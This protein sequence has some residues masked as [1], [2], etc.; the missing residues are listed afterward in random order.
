MTS[1]APAR[2][3]ISAPFVLLLASLTAIGP[4]TIDLYL[5]AFPE[6]VTELGT[7]D[8]RVQLTMTAT[9]AGL[10]VGQLLLG[11]LS[12]AYGR[13]RPLL[14]ALGVYVA[15]SV[16]IIGVGSIEMLTVLRALQGLSGGA[17]MVLAM[18]VVRDSYSGIGMSR[19]ISRLMLV[20]GVAPILAPSIGAQIL[21]VGSWR[22]MFGVLAAFGVLLF[23]L[24]ALFLK[25]TLPREARR[26]GGTRTAVASYRSLLTDWSYIGVVLMGAFYMGAMFAYVA[27][28]TFVFQQGFELSA[29]EFG[30]IFGA[31]ALAV[32]IGS[33]VNGA[34]VSRFTPERIVTTAI[35]AGWVLSLAL[36]VVASTVAANGSGLVPLVALL[37]PT[38]GTV[39]FVMPSVPA[40]VLEHNGHRA[41]S[42]AALNGAMGFVMGA[43]ISPVSSLLGGGPTAMAGV[44]FAVITISGVLLLAVQRR[45]ASAS[46]AAVA[47]PVVADLD[48]QVEPAQP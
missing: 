37:I 33:Q 11:S 32:T 8:A 3:R 6:I 14:I 12:D 34:L 29:S 27:S 17:G 13:R 10:A 30:Y 18:A 26:T 7:T 1:P 35:A 20:V 9:L 40:I 28:S 19:V 24:A 16:A 45:W 22:T 23:V 36:F 4:L 15:T 5:A 41:G 42:A 48:E 21:L 46:A 47:V 43:L 31:G 25:E 39:G 2:V 44:M 38:L